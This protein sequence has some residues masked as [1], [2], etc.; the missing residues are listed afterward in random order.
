MAVAAEQLCQDPKD[1]SS[2]IEAYCQSFQDANGIINKY[3]NM[4][5]APPAVQSAAWHTG[6]A[7]ELLPFL[8]N[9]FT[10]I[11]TTD[12]RK[13]EEKLEAVRFYT[14][15]YYPAKTRPT[16]SPDP[17]PATRPGPREPSTPKGKD[18]NGCWLSPDGVWNCPYP[19]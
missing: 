10:N 9:P 15:K 3:R 18:G 5:E 7:Q 16:P 4:N 14:R 13:L 12:S 11:C 2:S 17:G 19:K 1:P 6:C 8:I